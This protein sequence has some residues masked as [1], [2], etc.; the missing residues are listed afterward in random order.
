MCEVNEFWVWPP[1]RSK[2]S[3]KF[4][5]HIKGRSGL[6]DTAGGLDRKGPLIK[7]NNFILSYRARNQC[8]FRT[9]PPENETGA[10]SAHLLFYPQ[11]GVNPAE[12]LISRLK[13][14]SPQPFL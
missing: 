13:K 7:A 4:G 2:I 5:K 10:V 3:Y 9:V 11:P 1:M 8:V 14:M 12:G 6:R